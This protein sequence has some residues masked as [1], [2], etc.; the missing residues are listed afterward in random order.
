MIA[1]MVRVRL[2]A[3]FGTTRDDAEALRAALHDIDR[4]EVPIYPGAR[5]L[6]LRVSAQI[7]VD[8]DDIGRLA[9]AVEARR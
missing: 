9:T 3:S 6:S 5:G 4:F 2:P 8:L 1:T 7:Y